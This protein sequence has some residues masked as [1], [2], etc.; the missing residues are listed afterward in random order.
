MQSSPSDALFNSVP[1]RLVT[2][3]ARYA[4][5]AIYAYSE[6]ARAGGLM[7]YGVSFGEPYRQSG[8]YA[9]RILKG[10]KP[11]DL[12]V[13]QGTKVELVVNLKTAKTLGVTVPLPLLGRADEVTE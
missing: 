10:V 12:P 3:A 8:I 9:G 1:E 7:S 2:L 6:F 11:A 5:P 4:L 13:I